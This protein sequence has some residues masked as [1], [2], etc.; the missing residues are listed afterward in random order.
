MPLSPDDGSNAVALVPEGA[1]LPP[2]VDSFP[3]A[4]ARVDDGYFDTFAIPIVSGRGIR[5]TDTADAPRVAVVT[6]GM[7]ARFWPGEDPVGRRIRLLGPNGGWAEVVGVAADVKFAQLVPASAP[8]VYLSWL[9]SPSTRATLVVRTD[10]ESAA[11][12]GPVRAA[13]L[14][15]DR[16]VPIIGMH[17]IEAFYDANARNLNAVLVRTIAGMGAMGL[18]LALSGLYGLAAYVVSCRTREI[19]IRMALGAL[20]VSMLAMILR[21]GM[22]P[23]VARPRSRHACERSSRRSRPGH[24]PRCR[25]RRRHLPADRAPGRARGHAG[26]RTFRRAALRASIHSPRFARNSHTSGLGRRDDPP[27]S[28]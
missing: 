13:I 17:T 8:F 6:R 24:V 5:A 9:Q 18:L 21:Q 22:I 25:D 2:G 10:M 15:I 20:P 1:A 14:E 11:A 3:V 7:A 12:A 28:R 26:Q 4:A 19:G 27:V 23:S 16:A